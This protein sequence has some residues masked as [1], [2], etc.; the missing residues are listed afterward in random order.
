MKKIILIVLLVSVYQI[1]I[2]QKNL[3][4]CK[5]E[6]GSLK[7]KECLL[8]DTLIMKAIDE[9]LVNLE[10]DLEGG[11]YFPYSKNLILMKEESGIKV[12]ITSNPNYDDTSD[13]LT[14]LNF[15]KG[16]MYAFQYKG[17]FICITLNTERES[18]NK[19]MFNQ[20]FEITGNNIIV[21]I[22]SFYRE[23]SRCLFV[24]KFNQTFTFYIRGGQIWGKEFLKEWF[25]PWE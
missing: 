4:N 6:I 3:G 5:L 21:P 18:W 1:V 12:V 19:D 8:K 24:D 10:E 9:V 14:K 25:W 7:Y 2:A 17:T 16:Y 13:M 22:Y 23:G 11:V 20:Y 15:E